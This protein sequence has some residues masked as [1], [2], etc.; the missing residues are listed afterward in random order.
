MDRPASPAKFMYLI[1]IFLPLADNNGKR[2]A[3]ACFDKVREKLAEKFGGLT[4]FTRAPAE[5]TETRSGRQRSDELIVF[6]VMTESLDEAWWADYR[7]LLDAEFKQD[8]V[9]IRAF[10][11]TLL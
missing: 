4:A 7:K 1:E 2:F 11:T 3:P 10:S 9:L 8:R 6:E 5:G